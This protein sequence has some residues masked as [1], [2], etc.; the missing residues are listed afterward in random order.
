[1]NRCRFF[2]VVLVVILLMGC[3]QES[4]ETEEFTPEPTLEGGEATATAA[5]TSTSAPVLGDHRV[6]EGG[7]PAETFAQLS[8]SPDGR[9]LVSGGSNE[10]VK[11]WD[12]ASL[13]AIRE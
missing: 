2:S 7:H 4:P 11:I 3:G 1:M 6:I 12:V 5:P 10:V 9:L 13:T 8:W